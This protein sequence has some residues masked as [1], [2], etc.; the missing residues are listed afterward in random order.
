[1][2]IVIKAI[3]FIFKLMFFPFEKLPPIWGLAAISL[4]TGIVMLIIF[5]YTS[6]QTAIKKAKDKIKAYIFELVLYKDNLRVILKALGNIIKYNFIYLKQTLKPL[7]VIVVPVMLILIQLNFRY[8]YRSLNPDESV[9]VKLCLN[10]HKNFDDLNVSLN[11]PTEIEVETPV[12]RIKDQKEF[13]WRIKV[14]APGQHEIIALVGDEKVKKS[15]KVSQN[16]PMLSSIKVYPEFFK[17]LFNPAETPLPKESNVES[18]EVKYPHRQLKVFN[19]NVHWLVIFF[20]ISIISA[21]G[22]KGVFKVEI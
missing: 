15:I 5:R 21:F 16:I 1:M 11:V 22:L 17:M 3:N 20:I 19:Q 4:V 2:T 6:N 8:E 10:D 13:D 14:K 9:L 7:L 18:I 12:L